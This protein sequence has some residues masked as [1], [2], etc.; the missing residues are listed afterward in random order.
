MIRRSKVR[1]RPQPVPGGMN[2]TEQAYGQHLKR[3]MMAGEIEYYAFESFKLRLANR[4]FY[5]PDFV[6]IR[7]GML[8]LH[9]VKGFWEDD[10]RVKI[11]VAAEQHWMFTFIA[12]KKAGAGWAIEEF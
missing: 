2:K 9:E 7:D 8:E 6:V 4:T 11:K 3:L 1:A 5:T 10:A 12:I